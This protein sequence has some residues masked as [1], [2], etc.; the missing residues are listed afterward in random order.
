[1]LN[2]FIL[3]IALTVSLSILLINTVFVQEKEPHQLQPDKR[4]KWI[5]VDEVIV[6]TLNIS[7]TQL[8]EQLARAESG[9]IKALLNR[10]T[11]ALKNI[12]L[13]DFTLIE[14][15]NEVHHDHNPLPHYLSLHRR[16]EKILVTG[17]HAYVSGIE[18]AVQ[19]KEGSS[20]DTQVEQ[21]YT[22]MWIKELFG[23][24]LATKS[25]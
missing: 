17:D 3:K 16:I 22:H 12:W 2:W 20:V 11:T 24:R 25:F 1:M 21:K 15:H 18:Y 5:R 13:Q 7:L 19:V 14:S 10:D 6:E 8:E 4:K 23:W 9:E